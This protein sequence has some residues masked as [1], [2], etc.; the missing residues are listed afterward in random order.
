MCDYDYPWAAFCCWEFRKLYVLVVEKEEI[1]LYMLDAYVILFCKWTEEDN[2]V[3]YVPFL[4]L[5]EKPE[6]LLMKTIQ[7][8]NRWDILY[9]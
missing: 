4:K 1:R 5:S 9:P 2:A 3:Y 7:R 6:I 8:S